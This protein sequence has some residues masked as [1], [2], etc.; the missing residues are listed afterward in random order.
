MG[1]FYK[2]P[3]V[4]DQILFL[5]N[6]NDYYHTGIVV[7]V[8]GS[9]VYTIEGNTSSGSEVIPNGGAVCKKSYAIGN[10]KIGG[11]G[12]PNWSLAGSTIPSQA[13]TPTPTPAPADEATLN[14][15]VKYTG[16][17]TKKS[18]I[19]VWAGAKNDPVSFSPLPKGT[20]IGVCD[21]LKSNAA[22]GNRDW[23]YIEYNGKHGFVIASNVSKTK[24]SS[25]DD[26]SADTNKLTVSSLLTQAKKTMD[27]ARTKKYRYGDS[28][29]TPP[30]SD[31]IISCD[32]L[33]A[34]TLYDAG[35]EDQRQ[36]GETCGTFD[37]W[38]SS[39]GFIRST[40]AS[41]I[42]K[43]SIVMVKHNGKSYTSHMFIAV[44]YNKSTWATQRYDAGSDGLIQSVQPVTVNNWNYR[45]DSL[46]V[47]NIPASGITPPPAG[48]RAIGTATST[49]DGILNVRKTPDSKA[50]SLFQLGKGNRF[51]IDGKKSGAFTHVNVHGIVGW[52]KT[53]Y[54]KKD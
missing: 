27:T 19:R 25:D 1:R 31:K 18:N 46:I 48:W 37:D 32:R 7:E 3:Q 15:S 20:A 45:K 28:R 52:V 51:E 42:K 47:Y 22:D 14:E 30:C 43:G 17:L 11:Y 5:K 10:S 26:S 24:P 6:V 9:T 40:N 44:A 4:G 39:H 2:S 33:I 21:A 54:I 41:D 8:T 49:Y 23:L 35:F 13:P 34:R 50:E 38:L 12:R 36:G 29:A 16:Y 53:K